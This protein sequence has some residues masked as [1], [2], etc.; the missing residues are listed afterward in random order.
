[1]NELHEILAKNLKLL[2]MRD[3]YTQE[4]LAKQAGIS[5]NYLAEIETGRKY[6]S[7]EVYLRFSRVFRIRPY[8]LLIDGTPTALFEKAPFPGEATSGQEEHTAALISEVAGV[9]SRHLADERK[10]KPQD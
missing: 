8:M 3:G 7:P 10:K 5:K 2:R 1:V 9:I 6:P 4:T